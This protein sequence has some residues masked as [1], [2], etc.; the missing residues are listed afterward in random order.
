MRGMGGLAGGGFAGCDNAGKGRGESSAGVAQDAVGPPPGVSR[1]L[2]PESSRMPI[3][4]EARFWIARALGLWRRGWASLR[5]RGLSA[6]WQRFKSQ[7]R[8]GAMPATALYA[9]GADAF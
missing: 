9:P 7:F 6:S 8:R 3:P 4:A 2:P 5:T 1:N